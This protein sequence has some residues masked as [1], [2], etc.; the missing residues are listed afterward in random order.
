[1]QNT[2]PTPLSF[3][4]QPA[5]SRICFPGSGFM[6]QLTYFTSVV[7]SFLNSSLS[8]AF[9]LILKKHTHEGSFL[10]ALGAVW[11]HSFMESCQLL[12]C[13]LHENLSALICLQCPDRFP[14][15]D[16]HLATWRRLVSHID[17]LSKRSANCELEE[18]LQLH[19]E[20]DQLGLIIIVLRYM[21]VFYCY[22]VPSLGRMKAALNCNTGAC[23]WGSYFTNVEQGYLGK[24]KEM[25][26]C[27]DSFTLCVKP[28]AWGTS[29]S[30]VDCLLLTFLYSENLGCLL[31]SLVFC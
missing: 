11:G 3:L 23:C 17:I 14:L 26:T 29:C 28:L 25:K 30:P 10:S 1:M 18:S 15:L 21:P 2:H 8:F 31:T 5:E 13:L 9:T 19:Q 6:A 22:L 12:W 4:I 16:Y 20:M 7:L 27:F 24:T